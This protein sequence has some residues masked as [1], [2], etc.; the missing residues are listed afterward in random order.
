VTRG[1]EPVFR[2]EQGFKEARVRSVLATAPVIFL[3]LVVWQVVLGHPVRW[4]PFSNS[5]LIGW[6]IFIWLIYFRLI[7]VKLVTEVWPDELS[8]SMRGLWR[9]RRIPLA[10]IEAIETTTFNAAQDF[11]GYG[12]RT[13]GPKKAYVAS[14]NRGVSIQLNRGRTVVVGSKRPDDLART[15]GQ[16]ISRV[17][18]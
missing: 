13:I 6:T 4:L 7:T 16:L 11:G 15:I 1:S 18:P 12:I 5:R 9:E 3:A 14:G 8:I 17:R 2:E 10:Q